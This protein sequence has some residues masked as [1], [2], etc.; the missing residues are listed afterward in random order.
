[1][2]SI[3]VLIISVI[4]LLG[5]TLFDFTV[6]DNPELIIIQPSEVGLL[7][8]R[9]TDSVIDIF[10]QGTHLI[11][12][13]MNEVMIVSDVTQQITLSGLNNPNNRF[14][15]VEVVSSDGEPIF[16]DVT[17]LYAL[18]VPLNLVDAQAYVDRWGEG[19]SQREFIEA[20]IRAISSEAFSQF[21]AFD[22][23][24]E[25]R[26]LI[27]SQ[28]QDML[29]TSFADDFIIVVD[30]L[31]RDISFTEEFSSEIEA[32]YIQEATIMAMTPTPT[33]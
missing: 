1:M 15:A 5:C 7:I 28:I 12:P 2:K 17:L 26:S 33:P 29:V 27:E 6:E 18:D 25:P 4:V 31:V 9:E 14:S 13:M 10:V 32:T 30:F 8:S 23:Y 22:A 19:D 16:M 24:G 21:T 11:D 3:Y 20:E